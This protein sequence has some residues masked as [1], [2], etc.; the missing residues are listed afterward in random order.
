MIPLSNQEGMAPMIRFLRVDEQGYHYHSM[1]FNPAQID[2]HCLTDSVTSLL[3][4][5]KL[6]YV[7]VLG[8]NNDETH[9]HCP[10]SS[11][12]D[13][14][15]ITLFLIVVFALEKSTDAVDGE[16]VSNSTLSLTLKAKLRR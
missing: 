4:N 2:V 9:V 16:S 15:Y 8:S 7:N 14:G 3:A 1:V 5:G 10:S 6:Y 13:S 11:K 12:E